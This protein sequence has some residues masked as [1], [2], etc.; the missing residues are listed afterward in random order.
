[1]SAHFSRTLEAIKLV[2]PL[3]I[4]ARYDDGLK[5]C[6][7][8]SVAGAKALAR[9][10]IKARAIPCAV[11]GFH[12]AGQR[13]LSIGYSPRQLYERMEKSGGGPPLPPFDEWKSSMKG[14]PDDEHPIHEVIEARF[15]R[16]RAIV[17]LTIGQLRQTGDPDA[18]RIPYALVALGDDWPALEGDTWTFFY[19]A[20]PHDPNVLAESNA[21][22]NQYSNPGFVDD[23]H[24]MIGLALSLDNDAGRVHEQMERQQ[25]E[26]FRQCLTRLSTLGSP[27]SQAR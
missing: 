9:R 2:A 14:L 6:V 15:G 17:D 23:F 18:H 5:H 13:G 24:A 25:P 22:V 16:E 8:A 4:V 10:N 3:T 26:T 11:V 20:S 1:M 27:V 21:R 12:G 7:E 19:E